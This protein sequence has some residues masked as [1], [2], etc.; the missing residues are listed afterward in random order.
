MLRKISIYFILLILIAV[1][2]F[3]STGCPINTGA[4]LYQITAPKVFTDG[5]GNFLAM[6]EI[7]NKSVYATF[8]RKLDSQ[9]KALWRN[10]IQLYPKT[11]G[12]PVYIQNLGNG[13][14]DILAVLGDGLWMQRID[15]NGNFL[16]QPGALPGSSVAPTGG[17]SN[18]TLKQ[19]SDDKCIGLQYGE[20]QSGNMIIGSVGLREQGDGTIFLQKVDKDGK[21]LWNDTDSTKGAPSGVRYFKVVIDNDGNI[22][23]TWTQSRVYIQKFNGANGQAVWPSPIELPGKIGDPILKVSL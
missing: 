2:L 20:D 7:H 1:S 21:L 12:L 16:W 14:S 9:G 22:F 6:Y 3:F 15:S 23:I 19:I 5:S 8:M 4:P 17:Y 10:S 13:D 11:R 18:N